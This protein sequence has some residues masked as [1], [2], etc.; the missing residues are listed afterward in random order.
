[1]KFTQLKFPPRLKNLKIQNSKISFIS[2]FK[3]HL[4]K[5]VQLHPKNTN[6]QLKL[7]TSLWILHVGCAFNSL[8]N[9]REFVNSVINY[10]EEMWDG[11]KIVENQGSVERANQD[12]EKMIAT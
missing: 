10:T 6:V 2:L 3:S 9:G 7:H 5:F 12:V 11:A 4:T 1:M 8:Q